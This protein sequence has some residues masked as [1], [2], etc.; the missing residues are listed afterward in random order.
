MRYKEFCERIATHASHTIMDRFENGFESHDKGKNDTVTSADKEVNA[1]VIQEIHKAFPDHDVR[2]EEESSMENKSEYVWICDPICGTI[3][4]SLKIPTMGFMLALTHHGRP[5]A[6]VIS[7]PATRTLVYA[8]QGAGCYVNGAQTRTKQ[9]PDYAHVNYIDWPTAPYRLRGAYDALTDDNLNVMDFGN[10]PTP[11]AALVSG[12]LSG[13]ILTNTTV[14]DGV[15]VD[16]VVTEAG[17]VV[18][19]FFGETI[20]YR[21]PMRGIIAA[22]DAT[23][24]QRLLAIVQN[25]R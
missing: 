13:I 10:M 21:K 4:F 18:T 8:E 22:S 7:L 23:M 2:G 12:T 3:P 14:Y 15:A 19:D 20:D 16:L 1:Y 6:A 17:G 24:H 9:A 11:T 25:A 5:L